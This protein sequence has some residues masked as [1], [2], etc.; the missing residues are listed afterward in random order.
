MDFT[1]PASYCNVFYTNLSCLTY[2]KSFYKNPR[3][4]YYFINGDKEDIFKVSSKYKFNQHLDS[5]G[6]P[7]EIKKQMKCYETK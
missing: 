2:H 6:I 7:K 4:N 5:L 3:I 1:I